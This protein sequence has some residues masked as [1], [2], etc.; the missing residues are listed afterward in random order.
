MAWL[1]FQAQSCEDLPAPVAKVEI[2][3]SDHFNLSVLVK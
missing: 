1:Q 3:N 2:V